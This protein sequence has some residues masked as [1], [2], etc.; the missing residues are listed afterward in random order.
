MKRQIVNLLGVFSL[1]LMAAYASAQDVNVK[2]NIPFDFAVNNAALPAGGYSIQSIDAARSMTLLIRGNEGKV[3][4]L[5]SPNVAQT[6]H[7]S[8]QTRLLFHR[9]GSQYFLAQIWM[10]GEDSGR[11]FKIS[12][13]E[14]EVA[15]NIHTRSE[16]VIVLAALR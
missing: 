9:Y 14:A 16:D 11:Q 1:L 8:E 5:V 6:L 2:A 4:K 13:R 15:S 10:Q 7:P 3:L 12:R